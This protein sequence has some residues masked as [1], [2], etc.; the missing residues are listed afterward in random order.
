MADTRI[1]NGRIQLGYDDQGEWNSRSSKIKLERGEVIGIKLSSPVNKAQYALILGNGQDNLNALMR[2]G[3]YFYSGIGAG[4]ELPIAGI[5]ATG[6]IGGIKLDTNEY[7]DIDNSGALS[8]T[9]INREEYQRNEY[10]K[11]VFVYRLNNQ[12]TPEKDNLLIDGSLYCESIVTNQV[13]N[14]VRENVQTPSQY[15]DLNIYLAEEGDEDLLE[16]KPPLDTE[17]RAGIKI[18]NYWSQDADTPIAN[19]HVAELSIDNKGI[20]GY[21]K[22]AAQYNM[23]QQVLTLAR[24]YNYTGPVKYLS[25]KEEEENGYVVTANATIPI[26]NISNVRTLTLTVDGEASKSYKPQ[27]ESDITYDIVIPRNYCESIEIEGTRYDVW[28]EDNT[29]DHNIKLPI[30]VFDNDKNNTLNSAIQSITLNGIK[31]DGVDTTLPSIEVAGNLTI[32]DNSDKITI[33]HTN[34]GKEFISHGNYGLWDNGE[35]DDMLLLTD[36]IYDDTGHIIR[37]VK[38]DFSNYIQGLVDRIAAL[39]EKLE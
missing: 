13:I 24:E 30:M 37:Y 39:E 16:H 21:S 4:Y 9:F 23:F 18:F 5:G 31:V 38:K 22:N 3:H 25:V 34:P 12:D 2:D 14:N 17:Q 27:G 11:K 20:L 29:I 8:L 28:S 36:V 15:I 33:T 10:A 32:G 7:F 26:G 19:R 35:L 1:F 6:V